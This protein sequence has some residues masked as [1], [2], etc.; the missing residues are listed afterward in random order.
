MSNGIDAVHYLVK[1]FNDI[2]QQHIQQPFFVLDFNYAYSTEAD[3]SP[4][5]LS[6]IPFTFQTSPHQFD[7]FHQIIKEEI[8]KEFEINAK[9]YKEFEHGIDT[10]ELNYYPTNFYQLLQVN[11]NYL[12]MIVNQLLFVLHL[13]D[14]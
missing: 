1:I 9:H 13:E 4:I 10:T 12:V 6:I 11:Y 2:E 8:P 14:H 5:E 7:H 3:T